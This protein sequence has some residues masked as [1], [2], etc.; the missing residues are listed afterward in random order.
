MEYLKGQ[1]HTIEKPEEYTFWRDYVPQMRP[2]WPGK[3]LSWDMTHPITLE[4]RLMGFDPE[5]TEPISGPPNLW[6][7]RRIATRQHVKDGAD[8][9]SPRQL[10]AER[11]LAR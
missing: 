1:D 7:Y 3:L 6:L 9:I 4:K 8:D 5:Q 11:L 10:A 2:P